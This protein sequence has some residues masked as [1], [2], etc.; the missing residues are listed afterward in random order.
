MYA[1]R[2]AS[3]CLFRFEP[4]IR[5]P[6]VTTIYQLLW[7]PMKICLHADPS[8][9]WWGHSLIWMFKRTG[10]LLM[11]R[12]R[13]LISLSTAQIIWKELFNNKD[14]LAG[15]YYNAA[16]AVKIDVEL[17]REISFKIPNLTQDT[18]NLVVQRLLT[19]FGWN[20]DPKLQTLRIEVST[21]GK[22]HAVW[23]NNCH[24]T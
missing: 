20:M 18:L 2:W 11:I 3:M 1:C 7:T 16:Y 17:R 4:C 22:L 23:Q 13:V 10:S 14:R 12:L 21:N 19:G 6:P 8:P 9:K 24:R 15:F 5:P